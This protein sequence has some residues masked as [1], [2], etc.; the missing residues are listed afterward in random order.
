MKER[1]EMFGGT[2][3]CRSIIGQGTTLEAY[4]DL[5]S[6]SIVGVGFSGYSRR[7]K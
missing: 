7:V 4:F 2:V 5:S 3:S 1:A 6:A